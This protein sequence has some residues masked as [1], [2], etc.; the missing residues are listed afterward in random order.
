MLGS[1]LRALRFLPAVIGDDV[2]GHM[3]SPDFRRSELHPSYMNIFFR[4]ISL[5]APRGIGS[6]TDVILEIVHASFPPVKR[7]LEVFAGDTTVGVD[8]VLKPQIAVVFQV[9]PPH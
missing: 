2:L 4:R 7:I 1:S 3:I 9:G 8:D 5:G 6:V